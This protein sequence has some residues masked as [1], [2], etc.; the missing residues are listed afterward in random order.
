MQLVDNHGN[1]SQMPIWRMSRSDDRLGV[2]HIKSQLFWI[3]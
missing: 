2:T 1:N 3:F